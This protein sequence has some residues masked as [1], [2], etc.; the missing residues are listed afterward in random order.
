MLKIIIELKIGYYLVIALK[1]NI[2]TLVVQTV[3]F[4][5]GNGMG[6]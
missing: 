1:V 2:N 5:S 6:M 3:L 4:V